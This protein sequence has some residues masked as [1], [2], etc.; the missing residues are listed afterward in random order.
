MRDSI[1]IRNKELQGQNLAKLL[2][3]TIVQRLVLMP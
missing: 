2:C 1:M 3:L